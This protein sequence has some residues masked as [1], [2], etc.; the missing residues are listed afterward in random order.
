MINAS[1]FVLWPYFESAA[2]SG[3]FPCFVAVVPVIVCM[4]IVLILPI[5]HL[6]HQNQ[7]RF[8]KFL[9]HQQVKKKYHLHLQSRFPFRQFQC[10]FGAFKTFRFLKK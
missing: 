7:F 4:R 1:S 6:N 3:H 10:F 5:H 2:F 9:R 8:Q